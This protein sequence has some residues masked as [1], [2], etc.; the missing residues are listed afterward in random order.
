MSV[1]CLVF[2]H[3]SA[4]DRLLVRSRISVMRQLASLAQEELN[5]Q[6]LQQESHVSTTQHERHGFH[7]HV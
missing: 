2:Q 3:Y 1:T 6:D 5:K 4:Q 7:Q